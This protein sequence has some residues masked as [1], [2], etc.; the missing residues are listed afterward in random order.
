[1]NEPKPLNDFVFLEWKK[2]TETKKG[3]VL[4]DVSKSKPATAKVI[5]VGEGVL[6]RH[7]NFIKTKLK[8][9]DMV[10]IDPFLPRQ[11]KINDKEYLVLR[12][13]EIFAQL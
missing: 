8:K 2:E 4:S 12:E 6:D 1:M 3:I 10:V 7:G 11:I 5:A 9:G 13:R